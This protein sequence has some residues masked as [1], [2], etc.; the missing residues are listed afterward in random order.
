VSD[1]HLNRTDRAGKDFWLAALRREG[2]GFG[3]ALTPDA[4]DHRVPSCPDWNLGELAAH[5]GESYR[6]H[7]ANVVRGT[8]ERP[9][10]HPGPP[11]TGEA[12]IGWWQ[13]SFA[14]I[15][16]ALSGLEPEAPAWNW[17]IQPPT[18]SFWFR[19]MAHETA[20]HRWDAQLVSGLT[21]PIEVQ[22][23]ADG[24]DEALDTY[25]AAGHRAGPENL[26]GV[27]SLRATDTAASWAV[28][29]RG[30]G[31]SLLDTDTV[32][33]DPPH[34]QCAAAGSASDLLLAIWGRVPFSVLT[35]EG[36]G[37]L[38]AGITVG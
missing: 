30:V 26:R 38:L 18:V 28:R 12:L 24:I 4:L 16:D 8:T 21:E 34:A 10:G 25:L 36:N 6:Y 7:A 37:E 20:V 9:T 15:V 29:V 31:L 14:V 35:I 23:A 33:D 1:T 17:S 3:A 22:L 13:E 11:P 5:L 2:A 32:F 19:R 27:I